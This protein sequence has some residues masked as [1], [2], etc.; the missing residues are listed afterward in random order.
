MRP[1]INDAATFYHKYINQ[2]SAEDAV[3]AL[4]EQACDFIL[5]N[6]LVPQMS[7]YTYEQ[8]KWT[9]N[10]LI[11]HIIDTERVFAFR[12]LHFSRE[13]QN[14]LQGFDQDNWVTASDPSHRSLKSLIEELIIV[15]NSTI[16]LFENLNPKQWSSKGLAS[17]QTV[18]TNALA[19]IIAGHTHHHF[20]I[21]KERYL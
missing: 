14:P 15:R 12:A 2:T 11:Q 10:E 21:L 19:F 5:L 1:G 3:T 8:G 18:T 16:C 17:G 6:D 7:A 20:R 9:I 13:D 4:R